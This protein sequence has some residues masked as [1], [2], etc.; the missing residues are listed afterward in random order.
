MKLLKYA[1]VIIAALILIFMS[2]GLI[3]PSVSYECEIVVEKSP[4]EA[5]AVVQ[6]P[7]KLGEWLPGFQKMEHISGLPGAVGAVSD[8]Y[9]DENGQ[10]MS[11]RETIT[12][13][14]PYK[15][16]SMLYESDF[17]DMDYQMTFTA[18]AGNTIIKTS[19]TNRGNGLFSKSILSLMGGTLKNQEKEN[20]SNLK[21]AIEE[22]TKS[23]PETVD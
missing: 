8:V 3:T 1:V 11:I 13:V 23:Y 14:E 18:S 21:K 7:K 20:L 5:W 6:D 19:T 12:A 4:K 16:M 22:N 9:F 15:T 2:L 17:M 10:S